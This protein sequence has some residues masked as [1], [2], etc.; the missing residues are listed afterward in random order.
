MLY[1]QKTVKVLFGATVYASHTAIKG[2]KSG[3]VR[4]YNQKDWKTDK[5]STS[6]F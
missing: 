6:R 4:D 1:T 3:G 5:G 2:Q